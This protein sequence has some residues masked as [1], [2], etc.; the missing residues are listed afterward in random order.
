MES[1]IIK[2]AKISPT[3]NILEQPQPSPSIILEDMLRSEL[4]K[5]IFAFSKNFNHKLNM[6]GHSGSPLL[7]LYCS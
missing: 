5:Y 7:N 1:G 3:A 4:L 6:V 2:T